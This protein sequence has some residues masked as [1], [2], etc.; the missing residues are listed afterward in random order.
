MMG[1]EGGREK[2][3]VVIDN[4]ERRT[5]VYALSCECGTRIIIVFD[6]SQENRITTSPSA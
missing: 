4:N 2:E 6:S 3:V 1:D 5:R